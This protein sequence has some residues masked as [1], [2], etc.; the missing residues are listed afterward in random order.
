MVDLDLEFT[1]SHFLFSISIFFRKES[2]EGQ[3]DRIS[4]P[5]IISILKLQTNSLNA[6]TDSVRVATY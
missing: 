4:P 3:G 5:L 6:R 1:S 2:E